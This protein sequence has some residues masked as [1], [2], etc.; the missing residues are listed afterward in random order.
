MNACFGTLVVFLGFSSSFVM[1]CFCKYY[2]QTHSKESHR[3]YLKLKEKTQ[4]IPGGVGGIRVQGG[5]VVVSKP[6]TTVWGRGG[7]FWSNNEIHVMF[8]VRFF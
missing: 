4:K 6:K 2:V 8:G 1:H 5:G 7:I 3:A